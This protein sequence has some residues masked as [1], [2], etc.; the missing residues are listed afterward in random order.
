M[1]I[2]VVWLKRDL[3]LS[4]Q[5]ALVSAAKSGLPV[6][7]V[8]NFEPLL[9]SDE[10]Y[11]ARHWHFVAE[12]L[13]DIKQRLPINSLWVGSEDM[14]SLFTKLHQRFNISKLYSYQEVG[15]NNTF[16]RDKSVANWCTHNQVSWSESPYAAVIRGK[17]N[18]DGWDHHWQTVMRADTANCDLNSINWLELNQKDTLTTESHI[19]QFLSDSNSK[20]HGEFQAGGELQ[21]WQV[22]NSFFENRGKA[23]A[24]KLSSPQ[25]SQL[26]CSRLSPYLAWGNISLRQV[27][28]TLLA[29]WNQTGWRKSLVAFSSRL[30]WHCHFIQKFESESDMEFRPVNR[31]YENLPRISGELALKRLR[32]WQQGNTGIPM[33]DACM[34]CLIATGYINFR[35]RAMLVSFLCHHLEVD[36]R[37]GVKHLASVFLDFEPGIHY[38]QFQMQAGVTGINTIRIYNPIKQGQEKDP[39]GDFIKHWIPELSGLPATL[40]HTPWL[41]TPMEQMMFELE[42]GVDYPMPI[43]DIEQS[44]KQA[45]QLLWSWRNKPKVVMEGQRILQR[46]VRQ[47]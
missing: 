38:S 24:F 45:Q 13:N 35:M 1:A 33:V 26:H 30:H 18:R 3:R 28:K 5:Q 27:Y 7:L 11:S 14:L 12:S 8:Y 31:G 17:P 22:L 39:N 42:L 46:H 9:L 37:E 34:R 6:L 29:H 2:A 10:H 41:L 16:E 36:W 19:N 23:Y 25:Y 20:L 4:D 15:L 32:A 44:Y 21:A 47:G 43:V 40:I